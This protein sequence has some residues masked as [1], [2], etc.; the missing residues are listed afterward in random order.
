MKQEA[1]IYKDLTVLIATYLVFNNTPS[2]NISFNANE[3]Y[4]KY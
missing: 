2:I 1:Y 3:K 4:E